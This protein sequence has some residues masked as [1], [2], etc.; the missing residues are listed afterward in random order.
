M[1]GAPLASGASAQDGDADISVMFETKWIEASMLTRRRRVA[2]I[3][4]EDAH[5]PAGGIERRLHIYS[6]AGG[7]AA[8]HSELI[9]PAT[10][11]PATF[12]SCSR[13]ISEG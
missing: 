9:L 7:R 1:L 4:C 5:H 10:R 2:F 11:L 6:D 13:I 12:R 8:R 3:A